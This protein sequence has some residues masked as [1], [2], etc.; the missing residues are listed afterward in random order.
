MALPEI[1]FFGINVVRFAIDFGNFYALFLAISLTLNLEFGYTGIPNFGK[2]LYVA[3]GAVVA[4]SVSLRLAAW[5]Y[6]ID[7]G[8]DIIVNSA[9][10]VSEANTLIR[11][12]PLFALGMIL[13]T[14]FLAA[15]IG[16]AFGYLSS[17][18]AISL[19]QDYL[20]MLLLAVASFFQIFLRGYEPLIGGTQGISGIPNPYAYWSTLG[21]GVKD[22]ASTLVIAGFAILVY[23]YLERVARSPL[24]RTLRAIRDNES[25]SRALGKDDVAIRKKVLV[26][27]SAISG[28][29]GALLTFNVLSVGADT[30]TRI[31]Y[32]FWPWVI[33]I[34][35]GAGNNV[36]VA[37]GAFFFTA[38]AKGLELFKFRFQPYIPIDVNWF[39]YLAFASL[40]IIV[41]MVRPEGIVREKSTHTLSKR[42]LAG[43]AASKGGEVGI[44]PPSA[45][46][47]SNARGKSRLVKVLNAFRRKKA[48]PMERSE[49]ER[50]EL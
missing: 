23:L 47:G 7:T 8:G 22:L 48:E 30:W 43:L 18:P 32:T 5:V 33:V 46:V 35:G 44:G 28:M 3:A 39:Q 15:L 40:L 1:Y 19:R 25:A 17:Y 21:V 50:T 16:A 12:E 27:A 45:V 6:N 34:I 10:I 42:V 29:A 31:T 4:G 49:S 2:V 26:V 14:M 36:G 38:F 13:L 20:G 11:G 9:R 37:A 41:L 24:G